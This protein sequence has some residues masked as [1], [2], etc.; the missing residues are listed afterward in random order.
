MDSI[1]D[2]RI[3]LVDDHDLVRE[4]LR[5]L[6]MDK[7]FTDV[8]TDSGRNVQNVLKSRKYDLVVQDL[9]RPNLDGADLYCWMKSHKELANIPIVLLTMSNPLFIDERGFTLIDR[10]KFELTH[11][12]SF[13]ETCPLVPPVGKSKDPVIYIEG[14]V[15]KS[16]S[17]EQLFATVS[18]ALKFWKCCKDVGWEKERRNKYLWPNV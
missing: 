6:F 2:S 14:Y 17:S 7:G 16:D 4:S 10:H 9:Q 1:F 3:M 8:D 12:A 15:N 5:N 13:M 18:R 11:A